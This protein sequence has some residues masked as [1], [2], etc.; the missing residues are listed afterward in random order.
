M[1]RGTDKSEIL[2]ALYPWRDCH[3]KTEAR[4]VNCRCLKAQ[5]PWRCTLFLKKGK[6]VA[7][8]CCSTDR[9]TISSALHLRN[10][11]IFKTYLFVFSYWRVI[12]KKPGVIHWSSY[13]G[14]IWM[15][16]YCGIDR[17]SEMAHFRFVQWT[18]DYISKIIFNVIFVFTE[19][20]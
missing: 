15:W 11:A 8:T 14:K 9:Y 5:N 4:V 18:F 16:K 2:S 10:I 20:D 17:S 6:F 13:L 3:S 12:A 7:W 19:F 1:S